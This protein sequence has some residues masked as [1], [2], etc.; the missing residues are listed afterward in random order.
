[1]YILNGKTYENN[2][3]T[4]TPTSQAF[5]F[6][7]GL[8]ET[9]KVLDGKI[10]FLDEHL[11]RLNEGCKTLKLELN[12]NNNE[13]K[14][15]CYKLLKLEGIENGILKILYAKENDVNYLFLTTRENSYTKQ[16][17]ERG[18]KLM[19]SEYRRNQNSLLTFVKSNNYMENLLLKQQ[20]KELGFDEVLFLNTDDYIA[21]GATSNI[22]WVKDKVVYTPSIECGLLPGIVR[23]KII[24][25]S[26]NLGLKVKT[27]EFRE[28]ELLDSDEVFITNSVMDIMPVSKI[29]EKAFNIDKNIIT[30]DI[31]KEYMKLIG[32]KYER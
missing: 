19:I 14:E 15:D 23:A 2:D 22:F 30:T 25:A 26:K 20:S 18:F 11:E 12:I 10:L 21:E 9:I 29:K 32:E 7:Y 13:I 31:L 6:G 17:Y 8:F 27:G 5:M 28:K 1:M 3:K 4:I 16:D 24:E